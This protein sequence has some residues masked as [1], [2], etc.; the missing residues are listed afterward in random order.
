MSDQAPI[1]IDAVLDGAGRLLD[2][3]YAAFR[4]ESNP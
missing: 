2:H 3:L 4:T 1:R